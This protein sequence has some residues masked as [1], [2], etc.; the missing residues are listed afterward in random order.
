FVP[1]SLGLLSPSDSSTCADAT[2]ASTTSSRSASAVSSSL[3][4]A[5]SASFAATSLLSSMRS[6]YFLVVLDALEGLGDLDNLLTAEGSV[7]ETGVH[8]ELLQQEQAHVIIAAVLAHLNGL[9]IT[10]SR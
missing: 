2:A 3:D 6:R 7:G 4:P 1:R 10:L 5:A 9:L 8:N